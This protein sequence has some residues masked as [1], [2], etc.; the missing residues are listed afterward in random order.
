MRLF[1][2]RS[3]G[4]HYETV[5]ETYLTGCGLRPIER[6]FNTKAGEIDLIMADAE[7]IVFVEVKYRA[8]TTHGLAVETVTASKM[9]KLI[10]AATLWLLKQ[11]LSV[12]ST[13]YR[14]DIVAIQQQGEQI[15]WYKNAITQG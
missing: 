10:K 4:N 5:A 8:R 6:N 7:T 11:G 14:F 2:R 1:S 12:H 3:T 9:K 15:E 13:D